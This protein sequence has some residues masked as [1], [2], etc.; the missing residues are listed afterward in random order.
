MNQSNIFKLLSKI[1]NPR[2]IVEKGFLGSFKYGN[3]DEKV[4][5]QKI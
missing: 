3:V 1:E 4:R 5:K 2:S